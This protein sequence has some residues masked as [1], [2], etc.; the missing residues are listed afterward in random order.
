[1]DK[2]YVFYDY[3]NVGR[4]AADKGCQVKAGPLLDYLASDEEGRMLQEAIA[5]VPLDPRREQALGR[6]VAVLWEAGFVVRTKVGTI[7][8]D[9]FRCSQ[10]VEMTFDVTRIAL[11]LKPD[12]VVIVSGR[13]ELVPLVLELRLRG[14]RVEVCAFASHAT[15]A[16]KRVAS[17]FIDLDALL[18]EAP[19]TQ[20]QPV[21][22][23]EDATARHGRHART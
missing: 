2:V 16:V 3:D 9:S 6:E 7:V 14:V 19:A 13:D 12:I 4:L 22:D 17:G 23:K 21:G 18:C 8:G 5:Y 10:L 20:G 15:D 1:M 11:E